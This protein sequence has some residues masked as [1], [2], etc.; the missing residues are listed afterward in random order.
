[1]K[2]SSVV[3]VVAGVFI[4]LAAIIAWQWW[5]SQQ[6]TLPEGIVSGNGRI[7]AVQVHVA[8]KYPGKIETVL[9]QEGDMIEKGS[10]LARMDT[11]ELEATLAEAQAK[12]AQAEE[13]QAEAGATIVQRQSVLTL[14]E[15]ELA[16]ILPLAER[17]SVAQRQADQAQSA[18]DSAQAALEVAQAHARTAQ[19]AIEAAQA[20]VKR[21]E[22]QL[23]ECT[24]RAAVTGRVL[25]RLAEPG[26]MMGAGGRV[27]TLLDLD[28]IYM[29]IFI[30]ARDA[31]RLAIGAE[32]RIILDALPE[33]V[34]PA[35]VSFVA[36]EA[37]F[38]PKQVETQSER[39][40]LMFR[41]KVRIPQDIVADHMAS[42]KTGVRGVAYVRIQSD[43]VWP[44]YLQPRLPEP[45]P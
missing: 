12:L 26:E 42:V 9:A 8:T 7:E 20:A 36:P 39:D 13:T 37:Q 23:D 32:A 31:T 15:Q 6:P 18:R 33:Y 19:K 25:Y 27:L 30:P 5:Q 2:R 17:G 44:E 16:R 28:D 24:L 41:I 1:M 34:I 40:K 22:T 29:E 14:A 45:K 35:Q 21:V 38:T 43:A 4:L 11:A 3:R 10:V